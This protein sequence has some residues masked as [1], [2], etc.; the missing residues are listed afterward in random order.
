VKQAFIDM[1]LIASTVSLLAIR[2]AEEEKERS[3]LARF[4]VFARTT[5]QPSR[6]DGSNEVPRTPDL[7]HHHDETT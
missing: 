3:S 5:E 1:L 4:L 2:S 6:A 7:K